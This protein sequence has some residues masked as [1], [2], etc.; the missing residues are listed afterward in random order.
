M[1]SAPVTSDD[2]SKFNPFQRVPSMPKLWL[3]VYVRVF[4]MCLYS[5]FSL[6][7]P[8]STSISDVTVSGASA[9]LAK[10]MIIL[11][12]VSSL[13]LHIRVLH[14]PHQANAVQQSKTIEG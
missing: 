9:S 3:R 4:E 1:L 5:V 2:H 10:E 14:P 11:E 7:R 6:S 12:R 13:K 8:R